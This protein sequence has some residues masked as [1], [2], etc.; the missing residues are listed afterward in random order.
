MPSNSATQPL[1]QQWHKHIEAWRKSGLSQ[2]AFCRDRG[3]RYKKFHYWRNK[4]IQTP[5]KKTATRSSALV[6]V[7]Y[8]GSTANNGLSIHFPNGT[9]L[10]GIGPDNLSLVERLLESLS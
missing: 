3:L 6:P 10:Q 7:T 1:S 2:Q 9:R 8:P 5:F 4:M